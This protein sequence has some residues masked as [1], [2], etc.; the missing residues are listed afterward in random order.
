M[1]K[2]ACQEGRAEE[3]NDMV[4]RGEHRRRPTWNEDEKL[5]LQTLTTRGA[6]TMPLPKYGIFQCERCAALREHEVR[7]Y[8]GVA[9]CLSCTKVSQMP[10]PTSNEREW[11]AF[12]DEP[13]DG[14][15]PDDDRDDDHDSGGMVSH[16]YRCRC[17]WVFYSRRCPGLHLLIRCPRCRRRKPDHRCA[18]CQ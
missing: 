10:P 6:G 15:K 14:D 18:A 17:G 5:E 13:L 12:P 9:V 8:Q 2:R 1:N 11:L 16:H 3:L 7:E 4:R